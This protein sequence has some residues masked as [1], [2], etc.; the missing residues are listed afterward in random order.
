MQKVFEEIWHGR[1]GDVAAD[2]DVALTFLQLVAARISRPVAND[3]RQF[4]NGAGKDGL[5]YLFEFWNKV[6]FRTHKKFLDKEENKSD[7]TIR[8]HLLK[9]R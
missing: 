1:V 8:Q 2:D 7:K 6:I 9:S 4:G 3:L 5:F